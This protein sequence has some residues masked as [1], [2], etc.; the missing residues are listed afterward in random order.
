MT[1]KTI[2]SVLL[3]NTHDS[4]HKHEMMILLSKARTLALHVFSISFRKNMGTNELKNVTFI[5]E[6]AHM[7]IFCIQLFF[8][9]SRHSFGVHKNYIFTTIKK[10][11]LTFAWDL[12]KICHDPLSKTDVQ[13]VF[14]LQRPLYANYIWYSNY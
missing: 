10:Y 5:L 3:I 8:Y 11:A 14:A 12:M 2:A 4:Y 1:N 13:T 9:N 6:V 7:F